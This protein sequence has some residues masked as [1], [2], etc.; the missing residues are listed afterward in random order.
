MVPRPKR[1]ATG[2]VE[3]VLE[4]WRESKGDLALKLSDLLTSTGVTVYAVIRG[5]GQT[6][7]WLDLG[8]VSHSIS[9]AADSADGAPAPRE[10]KAA[11]PPRA[12]AQLRLTVE[13]G[14]PRLPIPSTPARRS[15]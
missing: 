9:G 13:P 7:S 2:T 4:V 1:Q 5:N 12:I 10:W 11:N 14:V 8:T 6:E 3:S 15:R